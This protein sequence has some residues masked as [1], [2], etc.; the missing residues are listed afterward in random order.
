MRTFPWR[1]Y[2]DSGPVCQ[3]PGWPTPLPRDAS[4]AA[5]WK[6]TRTDPRGFKVRATVLHLRADAVKMESVLYLCRDCRDSSCP[7]VCDDLSIHDLQVWN[8]SW[9]VSNC[10]FRP[11]LKST[12]HACMSFTHSLDIPILRIQQHYCGLS[13]WQSGTVLPLVETHKLCAQDSVILHVSRHQSH[14]SAE[15]N[16]C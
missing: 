1:H 13:G 15:E 11:V 5:R 6:H 10:L 3:F 14:E 8:R 7:H 4:T 16:A 12:V 2:N 9:L